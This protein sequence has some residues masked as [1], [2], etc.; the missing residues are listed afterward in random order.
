[1]HREGMKVDWCRFTSDFR[2][3]VGEFV[4]IGDSLPLFTA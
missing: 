2:F 3:D 4:P 1:M